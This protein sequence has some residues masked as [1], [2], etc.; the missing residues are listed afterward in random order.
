MTSID[1]SAI[2]NFGFILEEF[3]GQPW[4]RLGLGGL[5]LR[6]FFKGA[7]LDKGRGDAVTSREVLAP[8][9]GKSKSL[10]MVAPRQV[11]GVTVL[12][13]VPENA[14]TASASPVE[15]DGILLEA[16]KGLEVSLRF[17]DC[18]PVVVLPSPEG[19]KARDGDG[20]VL[21]IHSG[22]KGTVQN[23]VGSG[24]GKVRS[25]YGAEALSSAR[26]WIGPCVGG[27]NYPRDRDEWTLRGL[28]VFHE[29]NVKNGGERSEKFFFDI[30][31][32]L[33]CQLRD[34]GVREDRIFLSGIDTFACPDLCY[35]YRR[36]ERERRM[37]LWASAP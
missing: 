24:L 2:K 31:G 7:L 1:A 19:E 26:A 36:G 10:P 37:F 8:L 35:S 20:W 33:K 13:A 14:R 17:A 9:L 32:E 16:G 28:R 4:L 5:D 21:L 18:A 34:A 22:Y 23:I 25:R 27:G 30:A 11:H 6:F 3:Q 12:D 15:G 29:E